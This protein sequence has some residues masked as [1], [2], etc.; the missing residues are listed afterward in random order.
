MP[1]EIFG[2]GTGGISFPVIL[3]VT[4][5]IEGDATAPSTVRVG[6]TLVVELRNLG[7]MKGVYGVSTLPGEIDLATVNPL[8]TVRFITSGTGVAGNVILRATM[9]YVANGELI[10]KAADETF[11]NTVAVINTLGAISTTT[12]TLTRA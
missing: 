8:I 4:M 3:T 1:I 9:R 6:E 12:Y 11:T 5:G 7:P 2:G 10:T